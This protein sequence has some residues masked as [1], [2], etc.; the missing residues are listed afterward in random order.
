MAADAHMY[1][2]PECAVRR[3]PLHPLCRKVPWLT[4]CQRKLAKQAASTKQT[5]DAAA[6]E[7]R[8]NK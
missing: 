4:N 3:N 1:P 5:V 8:E 7:K 2:P 6:D